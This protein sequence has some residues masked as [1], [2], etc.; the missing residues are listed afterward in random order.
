MPDAQR[1]RLSIKKGQSM[2]DAQRQRLSIKKGQNMPDAQRR[3]LCIKLWG[4]LR[5]FVQK[6]AAKRRRTHA[7]QLIGC[8]SNS[9]SHHCLPI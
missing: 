4:G 3:R 2:P 1:Q 6:H 8:A 7:I 9:E 5:G